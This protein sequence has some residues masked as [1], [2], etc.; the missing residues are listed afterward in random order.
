M[1][2]SHDLLLTKLGVPPCIP[3]LITRPRLLALLD[4]GLPRKL[5]LVAAPAGFGKTTLVAE[6]ARA[7]RGMGARAQLGWVA[8][9]ERDNDLRL[10][11]SYV[12]AALGDAGRAALELFEQAPESPVESA[13][14][15]C[16]NA[17][18]ATSGRAVLV[19]D[20]YHV[21]HEP[22]IHQSLQFLLEHQ[23]PQLHLLIL[24]RVEPALALARL[25][26]RRDMLDISARDL[27]CTADEL[28]AFFEIVQGAAI[29]AA[30]AAAVLGATEGW[31]TGMQ[32][33]CL[34]QQ[35]W[36]D[37]AAL[38]AALRGSRELFA[39]YFQEEVLRHQPA[40]L[41][42]LLICAATQDEF[43]AELA[44]HLCASAPGAAPRGGQQALAELARASLFV[45]ELA[46][47]PGWYRF[48]P[49]FRLAL[50]AC[51]QP[52]GA[53]LHALQ[54]R[55]AAWYAEHGS[56]QPARAAAP[57]PNALAPH[58]PPCRCTT[59]PLLV[60]PLSPRELQ[61]L[62]LMSQGASNREIAHRLMLALST[63]KNNVSTIIAKLES[64]NRT[65]AVAQARA[66]GLV[67]DHS[68]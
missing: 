37:A 1:N 12:F 60:E 39:Q 48:H 36:P 56:P 34:A 67:V 29:G 10:F 22:A 64:S 31:L 3:P 38:D 59:H 54:Q 8:L 51:L 43:C 28:H 15:C 68:A 25:R 44:E 2:G 63:I 57:E 23:P 47:R 50:R 18:S 24:T 46:Q 65:H 5:T 9:D 14:A 7:Q 26:A 6:W 21:I 17:L 27:R 42:E 30:T 41:Q 33:L 40:P 16:I 20:D 19:L 55:A 11:W 4:A 62:D 58:A 13:L 35:R 45:S 61:V 52:H 53:D 32:L 49:L 66:L